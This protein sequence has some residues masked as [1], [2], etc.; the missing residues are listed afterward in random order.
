M[1]RS[2]AYMNPAPLFWITTHYNEKNY[3]KKYIHTLLQIDINDTQYSLMHTH[4]SEYMT[5]KKRHNIL[6][7]LNHT[8][9]NR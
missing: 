8:E 6:P 4:I 1:E 9:S 5:Q 7:L 2:S 3:M